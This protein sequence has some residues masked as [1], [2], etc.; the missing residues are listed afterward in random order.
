MAA[1]VGMPAPNLGV[2]LDFVIP[3]N[4]IAGY[5]NP[6]LE[7]AYA[8]QFS[9]LEIAEAGAG[10]ML[11]SDDPKIK[12]DG[13][14]LLAYIPISRDFLN[15]EK[16]LIS[17]DHQIG[18]ARNLLHDQFR[19]AVDEEAKNSIK[20]QMDSFKDQSEKIGA[21]ETVLR[22]KMK[23]QLE[24]L[25]AS[26]GEIDEADRAVIVIRQQIVDLTDD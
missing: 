22:Q 15:F 23:S 3:A 9:V 6:G 7:Q 14:R 25:L 20:A 19:N 2:A 4:L 12:K 18:H 13:E 11:Q 1:A 16:T 8:N 24:E 17:K 21:Q 10:E 26:F 5:E